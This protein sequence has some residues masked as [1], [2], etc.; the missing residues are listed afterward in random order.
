MAGRRILYSAVLAGALLFQITNENYLARF[1]LAL[2]IALPLLSLAMSLPGMVRC[3]VI[4]SARPAELERGE[5]GCWA[6]EVDTFAGLPLSRLTMRLTVHNRLTLEHKSRRLKLTGVARRRPVE[7]P[8]PTAHCG[9]LELRIDRV[10]VCDYLGL[11]AWRLPPPAPAAL[12]CR[13][14]PAAAEAPT[15]PE[16]RGVR[17]AGLGSGRRGLGEDYELRE[18]RPGDPMRAV[19]WK[20]S[21]KWDELI[22]RERSQDDTLLPLLTLDLCGQPEELDRLLD[23]LLGLSDAFLRGQQLHAVLWLDRA[24]EPQ[25]YPIWDT[26]EQEV[27]LLALLSGEAPLKKPGCRLDDHPELIP[28]GAVF[29]IHITPEGGD[30][31][32]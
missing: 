30:G 24:Q 25:L 8:A 10:R 18:Y 5:K 2:C 28:G 31:H 14:V 6:V 16:G 29:R 17:P 22:V 1:L 27:C 15:L 13:P 9:V 3:R 12:V 32:G 21:S 23:K 26:R 4:L 20:L 7:L 11:F 19:H